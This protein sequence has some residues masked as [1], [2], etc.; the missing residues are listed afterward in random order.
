VYFNYGIS[1]LLNVLVK[2][3][4]EDGFVLLRLWSLRVGSLP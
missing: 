1:W 2:G 4:D 3:G